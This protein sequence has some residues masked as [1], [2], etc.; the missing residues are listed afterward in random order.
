MQYGS[1]R[2]FG[3]KRPRQESPR[4][5]K[6]RRGFTGLPAHALPSLDRPGK[7]QTIV[8]PVEG[9]TANT[10][11]PAASAAAW[12][13]FQLQQAHLQ[14]QRLLNVGSEQPLRFLKQL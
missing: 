13:E 11:P 7:L 3:G 9:P 5:R 4:Q 2:R 6:E 8:C 12:S 1:H 10:C 14:R